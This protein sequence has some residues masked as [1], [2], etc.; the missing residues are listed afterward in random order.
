MRLSLLKK[1]TYY[2][3]AQFE[4]GGQLGEL[5]APLLTELEI[6]ETARRVST[7]LDSGRFPLPNP[8]WPAVPWPAF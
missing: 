8:D 5:L 7:L 3:K 2:G 1:S 4:L 6:Q